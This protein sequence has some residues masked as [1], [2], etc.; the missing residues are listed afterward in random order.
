MQQW[1]LIIYGRIIVR[2][3]R[4]IEIF[5]KYI[6][7]MKNSTRQSVGFPMW[8]YCHHREDHFFKHSLDER[9][10]WLTIFYSS[11]LIEN[12]T[13]NG[14]EQPNYIWIE[15]VVV[16][17]SELG[18]WFFCYFWCAWH[19]QFQSICNLTPWNELVYKMRSLVQLFLC[20]SCFITMKL[21]CISNTLWLSFSPYCTVKHTVIFVW[22]FHHRC[23]MECSN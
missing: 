22:F 4:T 13:R 8:A 11:S 9:V 21:N 17:F 19:Q 16:P 10:H 6:R 15:V 12:T 3:A 2:V 14:L 20:E 23:S 18:R 1:K 7:P 5:A